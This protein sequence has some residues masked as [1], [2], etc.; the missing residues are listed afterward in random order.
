MFEAENRRVARNFRQG[1]VLVRV[2]FDFAS[3]TFVMTDV[4][5]SFVVLMCEVIAV[6]ESLNT[7]IK[8]QYRQ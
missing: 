6:V 4:V 7:D 2:L 1:D 3:Q 8:E 5:D